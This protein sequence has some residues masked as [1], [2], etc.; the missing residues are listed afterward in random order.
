MAHVRFAARD[1]GGANVLMGF[2]SRRQ[3]DAA[4]TFDAWSLP[5]A[6]PVFRGGGVEPR[7]FADGPP[8]DAIDRAWSD[9]PADVL[10]TGTSHYAPFEAF[11]WRSA[12]LRRCPS[13]AVND[14]W[15]NLAQR[16]SLE[17]PD[18]VGAV[19]A[20]QI[21]ELIALGFDAGRVIATG[22]PWLARLLER[23]EQLLC[24]IVPPERCG[25]VRVLFVSESITGDV[26]QGVNAP[27]GFDEF[28]A[29][30]VL[31]RAACAAAR[32]GRTVSLGVKFHPSE[33]P[34]A[35]LARL[36]CLAHP[37]GLSIQTIARDAPPYPWVLWSDLVAGIGSMLLLE[38]IVLARPVVSLQPGLIRE[39]TFIVGRRGLAPTL[40][41]PAE[42]ER[43]LSELI[44]TPAAR[45]ALL[46]RERQFIDLIP[47]DP[48]SP[49]ASWIRARLRDD[50]QRPAGRS[51]DSRS[52]R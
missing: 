12:R 16:F 6:S 11:L 37:P 46:E 19:D 51:S 42:G 23:R 32:A 14:A 41:D 35:F 15:A 38:S 2:L 4:F 26:A 9:A 40:T 8:A 52:G 13:L 22:H 31:Y 44:E 39:D 47:A 5:P 10:I 43:I 45:L 18:Y 27:F 28:D 1:P 49:I 24:E 33:E 25:D 50:C 34:G 20:G 29:F 17:K 36:A 21:P 7:E 30:M 3:R 48:V